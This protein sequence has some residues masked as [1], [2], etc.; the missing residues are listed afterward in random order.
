M[1]GVATWTKAQVDLLQQLFP[2]H[3]NVE[4]AREV[5]HSRDA[6]RKKAK[7]LKLEKDR[8]WIRSKQLLTTFKKGKVPANKKP[9]A[10]ERK[11]VDGY[12]EVKVAYPNVFK[13]KHRILWE[14]Y[15]GPI[16]EG[17]VITFIDG[18]P[19]N[20]TIG[21][22]R[23]ESL[24]EKFDRCCCIHTTLPPEI[25]ELVMLKGKL[26][27]QINKLENNE[28]GKKDRNKRHRKA[29]TDEGSAMGL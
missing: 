4:I 19:D 2:D 18:N 13:A 11:T 9:L 25:R 16:P 10:Y 3:T 22:L 5:G 20:I 21:N 15:Y 17:K 1:A 27:R 12:W 26:K 24:R 6:V 8:N 29:E 23:A 14:E 28:N 7:V